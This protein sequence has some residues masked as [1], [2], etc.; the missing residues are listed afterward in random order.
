MLTP[1]SVRNDL[2]ELLAIMYPTTLFEVEWVQDALKVTSPDAT[3]S[4][5]FTA[6]ERESRTLSAFSQ[7]V[8]KRVRQMF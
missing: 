5:A 1:E 8:R 7:I 6:A 4:C 3:M 2:C